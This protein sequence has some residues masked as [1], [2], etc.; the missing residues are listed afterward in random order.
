MRF[1]DGKDRHKAVREAFGRDARDFTPEALQELADGPII[2]P[3]RIYLPLGRC[4]I[5]ELRRRGG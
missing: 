5:A 4:S 3:L 1:E 2:E